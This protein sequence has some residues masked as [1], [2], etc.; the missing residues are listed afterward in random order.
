[1]K[2][3][4]TEQQ[5]KLGY[6]IARR[7]DIIY[8]TLRKIIH[9]RPRWVSQAME[10]LSEL[11]VKDVFEG[12]LSEDEYEA[13]K[14]LTEVCHPYLPGNDKIYEFI[15]K[16]WRW[17]MVTTD[18]QEN[19]EV[20]ADNA[21]KYPKWTDVLRRRLF[22][23]YVNTGIYKKLRIQDRLISCHVGFSGHVSR[24]DEAYAKEHNLK[25]LSGLTLWMM[26]PIIEAEQIMRR[27]AFSEAVRD[28]LGE[29][30]NDEN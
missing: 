21:N 13:Q 8:F 20:Q 29:D 23:F 24:V 22:V 26:K 10:C 12:G 27:E 6:R 1:M 25:P 7:L 4:R 30:I 15:S 11:N 9:P 16:L 19:K 18:Q 2:N 3:N 17:M 28:I 14:W 5:M